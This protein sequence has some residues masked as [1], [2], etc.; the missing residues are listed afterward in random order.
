MTGTDR[1]EAN[2]IRDRARAARRDLDPT[3]RRSAEASLTQLLLELDELDE[4]EAPAD[5][6]RPTRVALYLPT[7][8]EVDLSGAADE[9]AGRGWQVLLP[10]IG[11]AR[12]M[13]F[14]PWSPGSPL[15][16]NRYGIPEPAHDV[17]D[18]VAAQELDVVVLPCVAVD[19]SGHRL[20]FGAGYYDRALADAAATQRIGVAFEVQVVDRID[21][22]PWDVPLDVVVTEAGVI[23][24]RV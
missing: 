9:V 14:A 13:S 18:L 7:D 20:G 17:G 16:A 21:P 12:S 19:R 3:A 4:P 24:P 23:R 5:G 10:V 6:D 11:P 1:T 15:V 2:E 8:G 22:A